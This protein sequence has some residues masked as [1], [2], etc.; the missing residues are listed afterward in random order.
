MSKPNEGTYQACA[1]EWKD[2]EVISFCGA[3]FMAADV[4][5][6]ARI[7]LQT[8]VL[9]EKYRKLTEIRAGS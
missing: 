8:D 5:A 1:C 4:M 3:H 7:K 6:N 2:G 9:A